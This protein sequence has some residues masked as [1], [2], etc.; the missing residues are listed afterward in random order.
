[1]GGC[2]I[3]DNPIGD[4][5]RGIGEAIGDLFCGSGGYTPGPSETELHAKKIADELAEMKER[6]REISTNEETKI[7][8]NIN[9]NTEKFLGEL[10]KINKKSFAGKS[11][12]INIEGIREKN[13]ALKKEVIG[14]IGNVMEER[15]VQTDRELSLILEE[16]DDK[17]R[18][19]NFDSFCRKIQKQ[20]F[21]GLRKKIETTVKKQRTMLRKEIESRLAEVNHNMEKTLKAYQKLLES[22]ENGKLE[23]EQVKHIYEYELANILLDQI[24]N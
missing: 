5:V 24:K 13:E 11:L 9:V 4:F 21:S 2:C 3:V 10:E 18:A 19:K 17:K 16:R 8:D 7:I 15:L 12:N 1:M 6:W 22:K 20:A 23:K 14:Y